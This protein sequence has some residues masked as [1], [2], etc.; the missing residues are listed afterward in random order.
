MT[1]PVQITTRIPFYAEPYY[2]YEPLKIAIGKYQVEL[3]SNNCTELLTLA[4]RIM[5]DINQTDI[6]SLYF[7]SIRLY[8]LGNK[9][10]AFY[11]FHTAKTRAAVFVDM[12]DINYVGSMGDIAFELYQLFNAINQMVGQFLN[13]Y[14]FND[15]D[16]AITVFE[17]VK[18]EVQNIISFGKLYSNIVF[19]DNSNLEQVKNARILDLE[20]TIDY[21]KSHKDE[22]LQQRIDNGIQDKY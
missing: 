14:G 19:V 11:W 13:G 1:A 16:K 5:A 22:I 9:D 2:N 6:E 17:N 3:L 7:L 4:K 15:L 20:Q 21:I 8:D 12:L 18:N 10:E